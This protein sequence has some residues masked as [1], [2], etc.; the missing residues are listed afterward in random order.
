MNYQGGFE[1]QIIYSKVAEASVGLSDNKIMEILKYLEDN[2][3]KVWDPMRWLCSSLE[4]ARSASEGLDAEADQ[5]LRKRI[6]WLNNEGGFENKIMYSKIAEA[7]VGIDSRKVM[8]VLKYLQERWEWVED[9][10][11]WVCS[12]LRKAGSSRAA[13]AGAGGGYGWKGGAGGSKGADWDR[14]GSYDDFYDKLWRQILWLNS[15]GGFE[16]TI[17]YSRV[18]EAAEGVDH[19]RVLE[20]LSYLEEHWQ[21]VGDATSWLCSSLAKARGSSGYGA[22][23][24]ETFDEVKD[25]KLRQRVRWLNS[26]GGFENSIIYDKI[27][28][29]SQ[30]VETGR[31]LE[32]LKY[33]EDNW[34]A[35]RDPT[36]WVCSSLRQ[37]GNTTI[38]YDFDRKLRGRVRW[39]NAE[40]GFE[41]TINYSKIAQ[42]SVG[43]PADKVFIAL[44]YL[45]EK[46][47]G[48]V[49]DPTAW[50]CAGINKDTS[51]RPPVRRNK[52]K[53]G[54]KG[55]GGKAGASRPKGGQT[56]AEAEAGAGDEQ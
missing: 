3:D 19:G 11:A 9:P 40:G 15:Q 53:D 17:Q 49:E 4:K 2:Y 27:A 55:A 7:A 38:D 29:A 44:K 26:E 39:L 1:N 8:D 50:V 23:G 48:Q 33:L 45:E 30:G 47:F 20:L 13:E 32:M 12:A 37:A 21:K 22:K 14:S 56:A 6:R 16:N 31:V 34:Q 54:G 28:E 5:Q 42:A 52:G 35:V 43:V 41:N 25:R 46:G 36:A 51:D 24:G 10:T 18:A